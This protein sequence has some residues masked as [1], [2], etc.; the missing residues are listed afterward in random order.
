MLA[1][2][3][4]T[5]VGVSPP[6]GSVARNG[7][8]VGTERMW[9]TVGT[10]CSAELAPQRAE[11]FAASLGDNNARMVSTRTSTSPL[12]RKAVHAEFRES[13]RRMTELIAVASSTAVAHHPAAVHTQ[14]YRFLPVKA[15]FVGLTEL[16]SSRR[17]RNVA[18]RRASS[19]LFQSRAHCP[20]RAC[21]RVYTRWRA[22]AS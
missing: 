9:R 5:L 10:V 19:P 17:G 13:G 3:F 14:L 4:S 12:W 11:L 18:L 7:K 2:G 15:A 6:V 8:N 21:L 16:C 20:P 1:V 22:H